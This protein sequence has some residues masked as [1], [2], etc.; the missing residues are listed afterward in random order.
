M[1]CISCLGTIIVVQYLWI[2]VVHCIINAMLGLA[3]QLD[4]LLNV[5]RCR[6]RIRTL[7]FGAHHWAHILSLSGY[8]VAVPMLLEFHTVTLNIIKEENMKEPDV[9]SIF[10]IERVKPFKAGEEGPPATGK[11]AASFKPHPL[12]ASIICGTAGIGLPFN[13]WE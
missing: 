5:E 8:G 2:G 13:V 11:V 6:N 9:A 1:S 10:P 4:I 7:A 3:Q 12:N